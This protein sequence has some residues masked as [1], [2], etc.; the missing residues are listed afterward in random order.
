MGVNV[1]IVLDKMPYGIGDLELAAPGW[2]DGLGC[3]VDLGTEEV[4]TDQRQVAAR[5]W[6]LFFQPHYPAVTHLGHPEVLG[7]W[8]MVEQ[9]VSRRVGGTELLHVG[10]DAT[11]NEVVTQVHDEPGIA[12]K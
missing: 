7:I 5:H 10:S 8:H 1:Q 12:Q 11:L 2:A 3:C 6:R 9:E 4:N